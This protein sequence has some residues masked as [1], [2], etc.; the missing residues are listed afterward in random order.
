MPLALNVVITTQILVRKRLSACPLSILFLKL[1]SSPSCWIL[2][3]F[4]ISFFCMNHHTLCRCFNAV[5][6]NVTEHFRKWLVVG[7]DCVKSN[8]ESMQC[9]KINNIFTSDLNMNKVC[10]QRH[11]SC[12][13]IF[14]FT[15]VQRD[16]YI[17]QIETK[18]LSM[19]LSLVPC[20]LFG[21]Q[22]A[23]PDTQC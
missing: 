22:V 20:Q 13:K 18:R 15:K 5:M 17:A 2:D 6:C 16:R 4:W 23:Y 14:D 12:V 10:Q 9:R 21:K 7:E 11:V 3:T 19:V 8:V 1:L